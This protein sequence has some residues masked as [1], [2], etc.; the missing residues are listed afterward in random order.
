MR[1]DHSAPERRPAGVDDATVDALSKLADAMETVERARG[2]LYTFHQLTGRAHRQLAEAT[3]L[4]RR[5]G[6]DEQAD[7]CAAMSGAA[8]FADMWTYEV[9]E[10]YDD[11]YHRRFTELEE[12]VRDDLVEGRRHIAEAEQKRRLHG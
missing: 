11:G 8:V 7:A 4:L 10:E 9:V 3:E 6:H 1:D 12:R 5:A 2:H